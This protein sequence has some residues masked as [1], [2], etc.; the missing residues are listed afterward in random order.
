MDLNNIVLN[1]NKLINLYEYKIK[2]F[3]DINNKI[4]LIE[5]NIKNVIKNNENILEKRIIKDKDYKNNLNSINGIYNDLI[6]IKDENL[7]SKDLYYD[8]NLKIDNILKDLIKLNEKVCSD[9]IIDF[10]DIFDINWKKNTLNNFLNLILFY[11]NFFICVNL[12]IENDS[13]KE[14]E[15]IE[16]V[17]NRN[18]KSNIYEDIFSLNIKIYLNNKFINIY[19]CFNNDNLNI[20]RNN[21]IF[22]KKK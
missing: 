18:K 21:I 15:I 12:K 14:N 1:F 2:E 7:I 16:F 5:N 8:N 4:I 19:G 11:N 9:K 10:L 3:D 6:K 17:K 22:K 13:E 20:I